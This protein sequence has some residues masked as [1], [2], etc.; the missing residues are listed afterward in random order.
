MSDRTHPLRSRA[1]RAS[2]E[3]G[4]VLDRPR[5]RWRPM[6]V[7]RLVLLA[8]AL[9]A[10]DRET[11]SRDADWD[12]ADDAAFEAVVA[13]NRASQISTRAVLV[14][15]ELKTLSARTTAFVRNWTRQPGASAAL[16]LRA[17]FGP[18]PFWDADS[19]AAEVVARTRTAVVAQ[20]NARDA[21]TGRD[22]VD[23]ALMAE[24]FRLADA[25][26]E[27]AVDVAERS[28]NAWDPLWSGVGAVELSSLSAARVAVEEFLAAWEENVDAEEAMWAAWDTVKAS[29][30]LNARDAAQQPEW[31]SSP[32]YTAY[33]TAFSLH[34][35]TLAA[36][37]AADAALDNSKSRELT[38]LANAAAREA[39]DAAN[40]AAKAWAAI[41]TSVWQ[42]ES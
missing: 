7:A 2:L 35:E 27:N 18:K 1:G 10:C 19:L 40:A 37:N 31:Q 39:V 23:S 20:A 13:V 5:G 30:G 25:A 41:S 12:G 38:V 24:M 15:V 21:W 14:R 34:D 8:L 3:R 28:A 33:E 4:T 22:T 29:R 42:S 26:W 6:S 9:A 17:E 32:A 36:L 16:F 11:V